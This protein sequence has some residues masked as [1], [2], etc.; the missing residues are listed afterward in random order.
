M[1]RKC[2]KNDICPMGR[3]MDVLGDSWTLLIVR[4]LLLRGFRRFGQ[5]ERSLGIPKNTLTS[6]LKT[7]VEDGIVEIRPA[8]DGSAFQEYV[9][10]EKGRALLPAIFA[11]R[12]W[13]RD[14]K[15]GGESD[16]TM[17][18]TRDL[19]PIPRVEVR[20]KDGRIL[21]IEDLKMVL[22]APSA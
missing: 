22:P 3:C 16:P 11:L 4:D 13:G 18:D 6:R 21:G 14:Y 5:I 15:G 9:P 17:V 20:S 1:K 10:T 12:Q 7:L 8:S 19:Q 2:L